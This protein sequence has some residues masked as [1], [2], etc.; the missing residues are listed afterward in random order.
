MNL[1][2]IKSIAT[3]WKLKMM[4]SLFIWY[5]ESNLLLNSNRN[6]RMVADIRKKKKEEGRLF[7]SDELKQSR[8]FSMLTPPSSTHLFKESPEMTLLFKKVGAIGNIV[9]SWCS[10]GVSQGAIITSTKLTG[11]SYT[12]EARCQSRATSTATARS[13]RCDRVYF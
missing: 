6:R 4:V 13:P 10:M 9:T 2:W 1:I 3:A 12:C 7:T 11:F 8:E 5:F